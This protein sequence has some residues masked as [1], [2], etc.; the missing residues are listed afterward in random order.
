MKLKFN[1]LCFIAQF[2]LPVSAIAADE[3]FRYISN[4]LNQ[5]YLWNGFYSGINIGLGLGQLSNNNVQ[6]YSMN[7]YSAA[8]DV[9]NDKS[10]PSKAFNGVSNSPQFGFIGGGQV[11]YNIQTSSKS[12]L[13]LEADLQWSS[14]SSKVNY[15]GVDGSVASNNGTPFETYYAF[16]NTS[17]QTGVN[18]LSTIRGRIG[19]SFLRDT[20]VYAT[21]GAAYSN[22]FINN[23]NT[24]NLSETY[25]A[26]GSENFGNYSSTSSSSFTRL[27]W[28]AGFGGEWM[29]A[30]NYSL[31]GEALYYDLGNVNYISN[32]VIGIADEVNLLGVRSKIN[33]KYDGII[34]RFGVNY[35]FNLFK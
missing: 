15:S 5:K 20:L 22:V 10:F 21:G 16:G 28:V 30:R 13:G 12:F 17:I 23:T 9:L 25:I 4:S 3:S 32:P 33:I 2:T 1:L 19:Y 7:S 26:G 6:S 27:G 34:T 11:G 35:H 8:G 24:I 18:W 29:F 31:K 14:M